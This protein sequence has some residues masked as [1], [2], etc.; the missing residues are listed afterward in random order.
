MHAVTVSPSNFAAFALALLLAAGCTPEEER[1]RPPGADM[2]EPTGC[3]QQTE[4]LCA[5]P[6]TEAQCNEWDGTFHPGSR[7]RVNVG[8]CG[9]EHDE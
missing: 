6:V 2:A 8:E 5:S 1:A 4:A 9:P 7:C 3:C